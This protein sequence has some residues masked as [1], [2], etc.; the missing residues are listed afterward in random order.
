MNSHW[1]YKNAVQHINELHEQAEKER[2]LKPYKLSWRVR[3]ANA[4]HTLA[5]RLESNE[6]SEAIS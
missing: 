4:L 6:V 3:S 5:R 1:Q 2:L